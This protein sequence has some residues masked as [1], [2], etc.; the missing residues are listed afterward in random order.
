M[1]AL[2]GFLRGKEFSVRFAAM[3]TLLKAWTTD[4][5]SLPGWWFKF[6][7]VLYFYQCLISCN[8]Y[9]MAQGDVV[10]RALSHGRFNSRLI[11][12]HCLCKNIHLFIPNSSPFLFNHGKTQDQIT[13]QQDRNSPSTRGHIFSITEL[14]FSWWVK[15]RANLSARNC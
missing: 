9:L 2:A 3:W 7:C 6:V 13:L 14:K 11:S 15:A 10:I 4:A 12:K 5:C 1:D 8:K